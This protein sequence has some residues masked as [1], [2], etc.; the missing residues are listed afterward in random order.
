MTGQLEEIASHYSYWPGYPEEQFPTEIFFEIPK[1]A[2][3]FVVVVGFEH[4][5]FHHRS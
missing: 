2:V 1:H 3:Q 5:P 4:S